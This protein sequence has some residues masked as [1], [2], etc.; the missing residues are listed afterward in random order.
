MAGVGALLLFAVTIAQA[1]PVRWS[2]NLH[3]YNVVRSDTPI[4]WDNA[5]AAAVA[6]QH[7]GVSG[8][9][10]TYSSL[11]EANWVYNNVVS[12]PDYWYH[13]G[14]SELLGPWIG[15]LAPHGLSTDIRPIWTWVGGAAFTPSD[16]LWSLW[17][18]G[19]V[20]N[21]SNQPND[22]Y[23]RVGTHYWTLTGHPA[24][25]WG[26]LDTGLQQGANANI[27]S[28]VA[29]YDMPTPAPAV[30]R[31]SPRG[32]GV[33][34]TTPIVVTFNLAMARASAEANFRTSP[35]STGT[36]SWY[37]NQMRYRPSANWRAGRRYHAIVGAATKSQIGTR[38]GTDFT[39]P[40][41]VAPASALALNVGTASKSGNVVC[42]PV[43]LTAD[44]TVAAEILSLSGRVVGQLPLRDLAAGSNTLVWNTRSTS[45]SL[46]PGG[47]YLCRVTA[48]SNTGERASALSRF[49][50]QR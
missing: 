17:W 2:G 38:L 10:V 15:L 32:T 47:T 34:G 36:F 19:G 39:W 30:V 13:R 28:Y 50:L 29:E 6:S 14:G 42:L 33:A 3:Y 35:A 7:A 27:Y 22:F 12:N 40:F 44:A 4:T 11:A 23:P 37:G 41:T 46:A 31:F 16:P 25:T 18:Y 45:G 24:N 49:L 8:H 21:P 20:G 1:A 5:Q 9:L 26:D 48:V 43:S